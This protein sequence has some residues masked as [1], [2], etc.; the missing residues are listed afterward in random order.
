M[1]DSKEF[2]L[3][4]IGDFEGVDVVEVLVKPGD[5]VAKEDSLI[6][7][8]SD[9][10]SME[11]PAPYAAVVREM[12]MSVGDQVSQGDVVALLEAVDGDAPQ[13]EAPPS[14]TPTAGASPAPESGAALSEATPAAPSVEASTQAVGVGA[15]AKLA[16]DSAP[17]KAGAGHASDSAPAKAGAGRAGAGHASPSVRRLAR[18]LG[19][20][21]TLVPPSGRKGRITKDDVQG[22]VKA[23]MAQGG[24]PGVPIAGVKVAAP[25]DVDFTK[26][27]ETE[28]QPL[29]KIRRVASANLHRSWVTVPHVTQFDEADITELESF[30]KSQKP[31][32]EKAGVKLTFLPFLIQAVTKALKEFPHFNSSLDAT[33]ESLVVKGYY[34]IGVAVDTEHGLVVP[35][36]KNADQKGLFEIAGEL[37]DLSERAR[38]RRLRPED[39]SGGSFSISSLGGIGGTFFTPIVNHPEVAILGVSRMEWK[40]VHHDGEFVPRLILP[41]SLSYDHRVIDGADAVRFTG[42]LAE[43]LSDLRLMLV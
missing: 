10:A 33:G 32:A 11:V 43:L 14:E 1:A 19:V 2:L 21:L 41:L 25:V 3:P 4:D 31:A 38:I 35:T 18:E 23:S 13:A 20:D 27:G 5:T 16:S 17:A 30:R 6:V 9:K 8:E 26:W 7:L 12:R 24:A 34:H 29:N 15:E 22:Y 42:R 28:L 37:M 40:P 36:V 39:L